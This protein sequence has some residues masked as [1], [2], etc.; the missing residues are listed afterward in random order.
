MRRL[1]TPRVVPRGL[2]AR[3]RDEQAER[4]HGR[5]LRRDGGADRGSTAAEERRQ[6]RG[7]RHGRETSERRPL[8]TLAPCKRL[9][10]RA[11]AQMRAQRSPLR[12]RQPAVELLRERKLGFAAGQRSLELLAQRTARAKDQRLD[13]ADRESEDVGDLGIRP[14]LELPHDER[15]AL[16]ECQ[17][18][19]RAADVVRA[20]PVVLGNEHRDTVFELDLGRPARGLPEAL[21]ADVVGDRDQ[22]V[23][24]RSRLLSRL[25]GAVRV[26]ERRLRDVLRIGRVPADRER[27]AVHVGDVPAVQPL[28]R[29]VRAQML[30]Q[31][32]RHTSEDAAEQQTL[33]CPTGW[34]AA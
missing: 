20:R 30:R 3:A 12:P 31:K 18:P 10:L 27:V 14:S 24:R 21:P 25:H 19:E 34:T 6:R 17:L 8:R 33:R 4:R 1:R 32:R 29:S 7:E 15:G 9:A 22:P 28:E 16:V 2:Q 26:H 23:L 5:G 11:G 13:C